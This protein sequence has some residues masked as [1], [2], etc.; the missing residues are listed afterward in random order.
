MLGQ[1]R[2]DVRGCQTGCWETGTDVGAPPRRSE[3]CWAGCWGG[4]KRCRASPRGC[5]VANADVGAGQ[6][7]CWAM[8][9]EMLERM[10]DVS[11]DGLTS[12][13]MRDLH[14]GMLDPHPCGCWIRISDDV[15]S[16][17]LTSRRMSDDILQMSDGILRMSD[18]ILRMSKDDIRHPNLT[19]QDV[20]DIPMTSWHICFGGWDANR[21]S[22]RGQ[23]NI[24]EDVENLIPGCHLG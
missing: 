11:C 19:S 1:L 8:L 24:S 17:S 9:D 18:G 16:T 6:S 4:K 7:R 23:L 22:S 5:W 15:G 12:L 3:G 10:S 20:S 13:E 2:T 21:T 14:T